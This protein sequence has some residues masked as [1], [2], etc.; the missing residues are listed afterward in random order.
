MGADVITLGDAGAPN[1]DES[2]TGE[3]SDSPVSTDYV[4]TKIREF[5]TILNALD[6]S[7][8]AGLAAWH[9]DGQQDAELDRLLR[10]YESQSPS[11]KATAEALNLGAELANAVG[12]RMPALSV[13]PTLGIGPAALMFPAVVVGGIA[14]V[15]GW[16]LY[17]KGYSAA[18]TQAIEN[19]IRV[20]RAR[21][22]NTAEADS[23]IAAL[24]DNL[25]KARDAQ[26]K[27]NLPDLSQIA[28]GVKLAA[29]AALAFLAWR[30]FGD[31]LDR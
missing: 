28:G 4:R 7:Y 18:M 26:F 23:L 27:V 15:A 21:M 9:A 30:A 25:E 5:Q 31:V 14:T 22:G 2:Y 1:D 12:V 29:I 20:I 6:Q 17:S 3:V 13:P 11:M 19:N 8:T 24:N 10:D 16:A